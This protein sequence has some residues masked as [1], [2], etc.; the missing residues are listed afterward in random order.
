M[1]PVT[2]GP[3]AAHQA[4]AR[5]L[6]YR[7][8]ASFGGLVVAESA[9]GVRLE[10]PGLPPALYFP[11]AA[12][13]LDLLARRHRTDRCPVKG[14]LALYDWPEDPSATV[15]AW[16]LLEPPDHLGD[17]AGMVAFDH[18]RVTVEVIDGGQLLRF[19]TWGDAA[20]LVDVLDVRPSGEGG[21]VGAT[22][23]SWSR[24]VVEGSQMLG[25]A[26]VAAA[27]LAPGRRVVSAHMVF[28]KVAGTDQALR[29]AVEQ[30]S[31]GRT[32]TTLRV[33]V[34]QADRLCASGTLLL[35]ATTTDVIRHH[36]DP[37]LVSGPDQSEP[38]DMSVA[39]RD[40][41][42]VDAAYDDDPAAPGGPPVVDSWVRFRQ[43]P[44][45]QYIHA[46]LLAQF[47]GHMSIAA[48]TRPHDGISQ[49]QAHH[50]LSTGINAISI[51]F[52]SDVR[53]DDW[54]LYHHL[55]TFAGDGMT[56][57]ECRVHDR[58][59]S[60]LASFSVDAM[61][62]AMSSPTGLPDRSVL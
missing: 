8:R 61:V 49:R 40:V 33:D 1:H 9:E 4:A 42:V 41:R 29:F 20:D 5:V 12:V 52:H 60:L 14:P 32:M 15:L 43:L 17:M 6:G 18:D 36:A 46:G 7:A 24:P 27:K 59:G 39:G 38:Y 57:S 2:V 31:S 35:D 3:D 26:I 44:S 11:A 45:H 47:C 34:R 25:Q 56:H 62:R 37:P 13:R 21:Y 30:L 55:S 16:G 28:L 50:T 48:A 10:E 51:S 53:A 23:S 22:R 54:M 19:P 58:Q